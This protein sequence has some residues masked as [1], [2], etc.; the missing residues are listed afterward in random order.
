MAEPWIYYYK[1][2]TGTKDGTVPNCSPGAHTKKGFLASGLL[3][4][5]REFLFSPQTSHCDTMA[6]F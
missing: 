3:L 5:F 2:E 6:D 4:Q 1:M